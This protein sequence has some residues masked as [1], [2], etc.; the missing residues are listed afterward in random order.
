MATTPT[1]NQK[2]LQRKET[3][4]QKQFQNHDRKKQEQQQIKR[5]AIIMVN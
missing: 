1:N 4:P 2:R 5:H 3:E